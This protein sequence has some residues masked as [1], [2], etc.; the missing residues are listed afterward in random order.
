M[1]SG[2]QIC[3]LSDTMASFHD[4]YMLHIIVSDNLLSKIISYIAG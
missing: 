1:L 4:N 2:D 3:K